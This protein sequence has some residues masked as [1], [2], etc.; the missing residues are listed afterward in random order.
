MYHPRANVP[1]RNYYR[2]LLYFLV[3]CNPP[4]GLV[5]QDSGCGSTSTNLVATPQHH[6][7]AY[8]TLAPLSPPSR[9]KSTPKCR[10]PNTYT[11]NQYSH[12]RQLKVT[13]LG[14]GRH[15]NSRCGDRHYPHS[16]HC[17]PGRPTHSYQT[18]NSGPQPKRTSRMGVIVSSVPAPIAEGDL[19]A[20]MAEKWFTF[21]AVR[22]AIKEAAYK[23]LFPLY[24]PT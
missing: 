3:H 23:T 17:V 5:P 16:H 20:I 24:K 22:W 4:F 18:C 1:P 9:L 12:S 15:E 19:D 11:L 13:G 2:L 7:C 21:L 8:W 6:S 14:P 10:S